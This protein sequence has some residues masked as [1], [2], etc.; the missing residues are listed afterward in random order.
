MTTWL[1]IISSAALYAAS[2]LWVQFCWWGVFFFLVPLFYLSQYKKLTFFNGFVWGALTFSLQ[3]SAIWLLS[4]E[5]GTGW[6]RFIAPGLVACWFAFF[7]GLWFISLTID[8]VVMRFVFTVNYFLFIN[9]VILFPFSCSL[10]GYP[11]ALPL[12]PLMYGAQLGLLPIIGKIGLLAVLILIQLIAAYNYSF[13]SVLL[14]VGFFF[15]SPIKEQQGDWRK[16]CVGV[17]Y[18]WSE[19]TPY[20]RAQEICHVLIDIVQKYPEK[21]VIVL[22]ESVFPWP[23]HEHSYALRMWTDNA[24]GDNRELLLGSYRKK[25][26]KLLNTFYNV[27]RSR[28]IFYYDKTH[29]IPFFEKTNSSPILRKGNS[30]FLSTKESFTPGT[31]RAR[32]LK[33]EFLPSITPMVCSETFWLM[34]SKKQVVALVNDSYFSLLYFPELM[35]LLARLNALEQNTALF[36]CSW[37]SNF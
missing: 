27:H 3:F 26:G 30:L 22:P 35:S 36:Y 16:Q 19:K 32:L 18:M 4:I 21:R 25:G 29:L 37:R 20:E 28:I 24:L 12:L 33:T 31:C 6:F 13:L 2:F 23:L 9:F 15:L 14:T 11:F 8:S 7:S 10:E 1:Y 5:Y 34:P 17:S